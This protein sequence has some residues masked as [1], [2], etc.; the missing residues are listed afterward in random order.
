MQY[1]HR[2]LCPN[3]AELEDEEKVF[4]TPIVCKG[5]TCDTCGRGNTCI[6]LAS[7]KFDTEEEK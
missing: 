6:I 3:C 7:D 2:A 4:L 1:A 5:F